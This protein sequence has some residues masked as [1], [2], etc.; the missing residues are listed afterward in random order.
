MKNLLIS[1]F[2]AVSFLACSPE[3]TPPTPEQPKWPPSSSDPT[4]TYRHPEEFKVML[5]LDRNGENLSLIFWDPNFSLAPGLFTIP[6]LDQ[7]PNDYL[8]LTFKEK[9]L[10]AVPIARINPVN[11]YVSLC[12]NFGKCQVFIEDK[13]KCL[14]KMYLRIQRDN[15]IIYT[16]NNIA[17]NNTESTCVK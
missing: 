16:Y 10:N 8:E 6:E 2:M 11:G 12:A 15:A 5:T 7:N 13:D 14:I 9:D 17:Y 4:V 3:P 1:I